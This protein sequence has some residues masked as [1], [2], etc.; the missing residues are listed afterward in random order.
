MRCLF[1]PD[2]A[3]CPAFCG[4]WVTGCLVAIMAV[5]DPL[6]IVY[7]DRVCLVHILA[8][9]NIIVLFPLNCRFGVHDA[10]F[11]NRGVVLFGR[12]SLQIRKVFLVGFD[13]LSPGC[14]MDTLVVVLQKPG[15]ELRF[16]VL[17]VVEP[18]PVQK[19]GLQ[20]IKRPFYF[21]VFA[22]LARMDGNATKL[23]L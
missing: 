15:F 22:G 16:K 18:A 3:V 6:F 13:G 20:A 9:E 2:I 11:Y 23:S 19:I 12:K 7:T 1:A 10:V 21:Q 4:Q 5:N 14:T 17:L 8:W